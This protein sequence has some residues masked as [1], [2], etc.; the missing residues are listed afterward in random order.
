MTII[1]INNKKVPL[2]IIDKLVKDIKKKK[3]LQNM[4]E[5]F[6]KEEI[7]KFLKHN[8]KNLKTLITHKKPEKSKEY[9]EIIKSTRK[10][11]HKIYG[12]F[13]TKKINK[14]LQEKNYKEI[15]TMHKSTKE[16]LDIYPTIYKKIFSITGKP[17]KIIDLGCGLNPFSIPYMK[18]KN[19]EYTAVELNKK[20]CK[21]IQKYF[22]KENIKGKAVPINLQEIKTNKKLLEKIPESDIC[23]LFKVIDSIELTKKHK[24]SEQLI[25]AI[26]AKYIIASFPTKT[27]SGKKMNHPRRGWIEKMLER[28]G[29]TYKII[30]E[31]NEIFYVIK[32]QD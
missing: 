5:N 11:L 7:K 19:I 2:S 27:L 3:G 25:K 29:Y 28:I 14:L 16:R 31:K 24:T 15:L 26:P 4:D 32:K 1:T 10:T 20:D 18:L 12:A 9:K 30:K 23:F 6:I 17:K 8:S 21:T 22:D 13:K